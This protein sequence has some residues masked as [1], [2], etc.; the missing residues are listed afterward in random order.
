[1]TC[2]TICSHL[3]HVVFDHDLYKLFECRLLRIPTEFLLGLG[4]ISPKV[5]YIGRTIEV[6][7]NRDNNLAVS[8]IDTLFVYALAFPAEFNACVMEC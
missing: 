6:F 8:G 5:Y 2:D 3:A 7:R 1:M 4:R